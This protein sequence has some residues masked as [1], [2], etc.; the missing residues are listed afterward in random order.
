MTPDRPHYEG[1]HSANDDLIEIPDH[2][3]GTGPLQRLEVVAPVDADHTTE[4][5]GPPR[6]YP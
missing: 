5:P 3:V 2:E 1:G 6:L 4:A